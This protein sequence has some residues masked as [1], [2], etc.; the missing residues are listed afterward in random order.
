MWCNRWSAQTLWSWRFVCFKQHLF[1]QSHFTHFAM[2]TVI[3]KGVPVGATSAA[4]PTAGN[5]VEAFAASAADL[6]PLICRPLGASTWH[7]G[8]TKVI[9]LMRASVLAG[10]CCGQTILKY[11]REHASDSTTP[12]TDAMQFLY[13]HWAQLL[14][15]YQMDVLRAS[16]VGELAHA[17]PE[18]RTHLIYQRFMYKK[19]NALRRQGHLAMRPNDCAGKGE[20]SRSVVRNACISAVYSQLALCQGLSGNV[21][22][23]HS[24][25]Q[26]LPHWHWRTSSCTQHVFWRGVSNCVQLPW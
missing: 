14:T 12:I 3:D 10:S 21:C 7:R 25:R 11:M 18:R 2:E 4:G 9:A 23:R 5:Q 1:N 17:S 16:E 26:P 15:Q 19:R 24:S 20:S 8:S 6:A 13:P 22:Q